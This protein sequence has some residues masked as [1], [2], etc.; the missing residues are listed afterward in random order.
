MTPTQRKIARILVS[1]GASR[2]EIARQLYLSVPTVNKHLD[3]MYNETGMSTMLELAVKIIY[4]VRLM[5]E[6]MEVKGIA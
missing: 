2:A 4:D 3:A 5:T 6:V 1:Q